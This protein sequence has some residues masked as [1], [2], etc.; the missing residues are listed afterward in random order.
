[1]GVSWLNYV[2]EVWFH[3]GDRGFILRWGSRSSLVVGIR[4]RDGDGVG[5]NDICFY[6]DLL[7]YYFPNTKG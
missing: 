6:S 4:F 1:M 5:M 2:V 7:Y 3:D